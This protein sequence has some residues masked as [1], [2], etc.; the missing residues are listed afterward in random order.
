MKH[1]QL[2]EHSNECVAK[3]QKW[4]EKTDKKWYEVYYPCSTNVILFYV[5]GEFILF[6]LAECNRYDKCSRLN[7][8]EYWVKE[9]LKLFSNQNPKKTLY[10][11][12]N[13]GIT[14]Y[15]NWRNETKRN[16][17]YNERHSEINYIYHSASKKEYYFTTDYDFLSFINNNTNIHNEIK[18]TAEYIKQTFPDQENKLLRQLDDLGY[19]NSMPYDINLN[20]D[21]FVYRTMNEL[22][23]TIKT[24]TK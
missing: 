14:D 6:E 15:R 5:K 16:I 12:F 21:K 9:I 11:T 7:D 20:N 2:T 23:K 24:E 10:Y 3:K 17:I 22:I 4:K 18:K 19:K 8:N 13:R 1:I